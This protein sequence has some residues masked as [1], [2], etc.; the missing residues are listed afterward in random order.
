MWKASK[1]SSS[2]PHGVVLALS[3][4]V[5]DKTDDEALLCNADFPCPRLRWGRKPFSSCMCAFQY[6]LVQAH[7]HARTQREGGGGGRGKRGEKVNDR[8]RAQ[9]INQNL[10]F[11]FEFV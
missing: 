9:T 1:Q 2:N 3:V 4:A 5:T 11:L 8:F 7:A 6:T 10:I